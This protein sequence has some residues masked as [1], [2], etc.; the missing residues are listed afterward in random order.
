[1][2]DRSEINDGRVTRYYTTTHFRAELKKRGALINNKVS[3][4]LIP[5]SLEEGLRAHSGTWL[6]RGYRGQ[7]RHAALLKDP[8]YNAL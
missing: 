3:K 1:M 8:H 5:L 6:L 7:M 2:L 4:F